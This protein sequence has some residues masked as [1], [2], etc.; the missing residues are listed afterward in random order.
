[1]MI[2]VLKVKVQMMMM[3][4]TTTTNMMTHMLLNM[5]INMMLN[6]MINMMINMM[7]KMMVKMMVNMMLMVVR[8]QMK[9]NASTKSPG[10]LNRL[11]LHSIDL[12]QRGTLVVWYAKLAMNMHLFIAKWAT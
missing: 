11:F 4:M 6:M 10:P 7:V 12:G 5:M 8:H 9:D 3:M 2:V 1:M